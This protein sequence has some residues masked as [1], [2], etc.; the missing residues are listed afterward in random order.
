M[1]IKVKRST[2]ASN[3]SLSIGVALCLFAASIPYWGESS[4][5]RE[6]VEISCYFIFAMMWNLLAGFGGMVSVGQ[7]AFFG[8]GGYAMLSMGNFLGINPFLAVPLAALVAAL[9]SILVSKV[10]FRLH[11]G[12]FSIGTW[13]I[14]EVIR[15][16]IANISAVGG[17]S[18]TDCRRAPSPV[19]A[20]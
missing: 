12:Y 4:W 8:L 7:Q 1:D 3:I 10:A 20:R 18:G 11:G 14:A 13:V 15:L 6:F 16:T 19:R 5:M 2:R 17:G 9:I